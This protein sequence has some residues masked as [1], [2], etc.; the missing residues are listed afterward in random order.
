M[1]DK[2]SIKNV[3]AALHKY[4]RPFWVISFVEGTRIRPKK[5][6]QSQ[7]FASQR[8]LYVPKH[9][10]VP[11]TKGFIA[12]MEGLRERA[13][14]IYD[15]TIAYEE[16]VPSMWQWYK[17]YSKGVHVHIKRFSAKDLPMDE[18]GLSEW[19]YGRFEEKDKKLDAFYKE[20]MFN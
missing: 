16:G 19:L 6:A 20:G 2:N 10:L 4:S 11:R 8:N 18:A 12:A 13:D 5:L 15:I 14:A 9:T 17:G 7:E 3:F 1:K